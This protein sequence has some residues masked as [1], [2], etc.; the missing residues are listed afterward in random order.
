[1]PGAGAINFAEVIA[2]IAGT[3][4]DGWLTVELYPY[5]D[6]P[7]TAAHEAIEVLRPLVEA[8]QP[9]LPR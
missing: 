6:D 9:S 5:I 8:A 3:G 1:V 4:Y 2:A 7:D